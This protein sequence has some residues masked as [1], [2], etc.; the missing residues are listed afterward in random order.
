LDTINGFCSLSHFIPLDIGIV[1]VPFSPAL[2]ASFLTLGDGEAIDSLI[3]DLSLPSLHPPSFP[4]DF[5]TSCLLLVSSGR[6][7]LARALPL[8]FFLLPLFVLL[9]LPCT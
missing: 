7:G 5:I 8:L 2:Y 1:T 3:F 9:V 4:R 6:S